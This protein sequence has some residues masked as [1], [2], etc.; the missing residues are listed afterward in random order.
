MAT[1]VPGLHHFCFKVD[2]VDAA[3]ERFPILSRPH[4]IRELKAS[5]PYF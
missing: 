4:L 5:A 1:N 2:D 3:K